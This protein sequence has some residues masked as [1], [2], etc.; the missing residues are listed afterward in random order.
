[1]Y[2]AESRYLR[3]MEQ[4]EQG[5]FKGQ[6][7]VTPEEAADMTNLP[8]LQYGS[9]FVLHGRFLAAYRPWAFVV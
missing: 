6:V 7:R 9:L 4:N 3:I 2:V 5:V 8:W 1:M